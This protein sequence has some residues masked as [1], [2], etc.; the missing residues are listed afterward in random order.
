M[1]QR[2]TRRTVLKGM[3]AGTAGLALAGPILRAQSPSTKLNV[4]G[5]G[6]GGMMGMG[7]LGP[8]GQ[9]KQVNVAALCD[10]DSNHLAGAAK[11]FPSARKYSD[12]REMLAKEGD[13]IDAVTVC[14]P[15]HMHAAI[16]V[17]A[18]RAGKHVYCQKPLAHDVF[19]VRQMELEAR[20]AGVVTQLGT[21]HASGIGDRMGVQMIRAGAIG[22][23]REVFMWS[24]RPGHEGYRR[25]DPRPAKSDPI[26]KHINWDL[27]LGTA[28]E[29]APQGRTSRPGPRTG[30]SAWLLPWIL[31]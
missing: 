24:N 18:M 26:P 19:E 10:I 17:S 1:S 28:P 14:T 12:W 5:I 25:V 13:R 9:H 7:T 3:T 11:R 21:Q 23:I 30:T 8:V 20:K 4:A 2:H 31:Q 29:I 15:D 22:K 16:S 27:W 6:V